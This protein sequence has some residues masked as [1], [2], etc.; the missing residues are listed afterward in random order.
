M[1]PICLLHFLWAVCSGA[2]SLGTPLPPLPVLCRDLMAGAID[3]GLE[4]SSAGIG[5]A[6]GALEGLPTVLSVAL[7]VPLCAIAVAALSAFVLLLCMHFHKVLGRTRSLD[8]KRLLPTAFQE[9]PPL[10]HHHHHHHKHW[11]LHIRPTNREHVK[12][13]A[14]LTAT[15]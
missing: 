13:I 15:L 10:L 11:G 4:G 12:P 3:V 8:E 6:T 2:Q 5:A 7:Q 14:C 1:F 9:H